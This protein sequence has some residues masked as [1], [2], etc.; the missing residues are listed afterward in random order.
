MDVAQRQKAH[1]KYQPMVL[2]AIARRC[3]TKGEVPHGFLRCPINRI[4]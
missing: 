2:R 4:L 1:L 3:R